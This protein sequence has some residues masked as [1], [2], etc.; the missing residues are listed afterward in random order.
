[1]NKTATLTEIEEHWSFNDVLTANLLLDAEII[2]Q[3]LAT[4]R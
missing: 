2:Y 1:M 4:Q 3:Y